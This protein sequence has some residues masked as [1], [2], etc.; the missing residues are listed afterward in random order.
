VKTISL[1]KVAAV[2]VASLGFGL[3]SVVPAQAAVSAVSISA[4]VALANGGTATA[5]TATQAVANQVT[6]SV[7]ATGTGT[8]Y[9]NYSGV[10]S[11]QTATDTNDIAAGVADPDTAWTALNGVNYTNGGSTDSDVTADIH[12]FTF[13]SLTAGTQTVRFQVVDALTG[14]YTTLGT[15][16]ITWA[17]AANT[18]L[19]SVSAYV[20]ANAAVCN[21]S[22]AASTVGSQDRANAT[23]LVLCVVLKNNLSSAYLRSTAVSIVSNGVGLVDGAAVA[24]NGAVTAGFQAFAITGNGLPGTMELTI[25]AS[26]AAADGVTTVAK[27]TTAKVIN[28]GDFTAISLANLKQSI[29]ISGATAAIDYAATDAKA[30]AAAIDLSSGATWYV[31]S[32]KGTTAVSSTAPNNSSATIASTA[33]ETITAL[34]G[35]SADAGRASVTAGAAYEKL[36]IWVTK[37]NA[38][39]TT[40]TSNK[41]VVYVST[42]IT[43]VKSVTVTTAPSTAGSGATTLTIQA[44]SDPA[45]TTTAYPVVD[46]AALTFGSTGGSLSTTSTTIGSKGTATVDFYPSQVGGDSAVTITAT[47]PATKVTVVQKV[48]TVGTNILTQIDALN[49]KIVALNALIAKIMKKLGVK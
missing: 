21:G 16:V 23:A 47:D 27:T 9:V 1:K 33:A 41:I 25:S 15:V 5:R 3:L 17:D 6:A 42:A 31:E 28:N 49:A 48:P 14:L 11:I 24:A 34:T 36:T 44:M 19:G 4:P 38:A 8:L 46:G 12:N 40:V 29:A 26:S 22:T 13:T 7:T 30:N 18:D 2:A 39:G 45:T 32:D 43:A 37:K 10:G 35:A 20:L